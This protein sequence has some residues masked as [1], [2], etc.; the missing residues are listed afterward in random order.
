MRA[1]LLKNVETLQIGPCAVSAGCLRMPR[2]ACVNRPP[3]WRQM[4]SDGDTVDY[5]PVDGCLRILTKVD[6]SPPP[7]LAQP[8]I[9]RGAGAPCPHF[10][11]AEGRAVPAAAAENDEECQGALAFPTIGP[12]FRM[13]RTREMMRNSGK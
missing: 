12:A 2:S 8:A 7:P 11:P 13:L 1:A 6:I 9:D 5:A 4:V 3:K 10:R